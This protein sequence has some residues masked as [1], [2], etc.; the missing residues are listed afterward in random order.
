MY[1]LAFSTLR[2]N[3]APFAVIVFVVVV[4][5]MLMTANG[6]VSLVFA[7]L[8]MLY[9]HRIIQLGETYG[10]SDPLSTTG[11]DGSKI[12]IVG[13]LL[14]FLVFFV[15]LMLFLAAS[16]MVLNASGML[17][18][19]AFLS[20][21]EYAMWG[22]LLGVPAFACAFALIGTVLPACAERGDTSLRAALA[23]GRKTFGRTLLNLTIGPVVMSVLAFAIMGQIGWLL[24]SLGGFIVQIVFHTTATILMI[25]PAL[26]TAS[27]LSQ[28][29]L[30][31]QSR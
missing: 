9:A 4:L 24:G 23:R 6:V 15:A 11:K 20:E 1:G 19:N 27:A 22:V 26:L 7:G 29:Y 16:F 18:P 21:I 8:S 25:I 30:Q 3:P 17:D 5:E 31:A 13:Y 14:R 12:P 10:W 2:T 28:A